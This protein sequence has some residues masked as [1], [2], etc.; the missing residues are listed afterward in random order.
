MRAALIMTLGILALPPAGHVL[1][2]PAGSVMERQAQ[3]ITA[4]T[5]AR[6]PEDYQ[7]LWRT[8]N[9]RGSGGGGFFG[10]P[11][12]GTPSRHDNPQACDVLWQRVYWMDIRSLHV[13]IGLT[14]RSD[15]RQFYSI[16]R[17]E[18]AGDS[19]SVIF[20]SNIKIS[21]LETDQITLR[22]NGQQLFFTVSTMGMRYSCELVP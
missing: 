4:A 1:A 2:S 10:G 16:E 3:M 9:G 18:S 20:A 19:L 7:G 15:L 21:T 8:V 22:R 14:P 12:G 5:G 11:P 13:S 17:V 6:I